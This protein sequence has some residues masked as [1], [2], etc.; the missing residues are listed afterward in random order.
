MRDSNI[1]LLRLFCIIAI[2]AYH[3]CVY[4]EWEYD[5]STIS[6][7]RFFLQFICV[8]G[9]LGVNCFVLIS[10]YYLVEKERRSPSSI[11]KIWLAL[12][13]Y[14]LLFPTVFMLFGMQP[15]SV[16]ELAFSCAPV[17]RQTWEFASA[18]FVLMLLVPYINRLLKVLS[19]KEYQR[20]LILVLTIWCLIPTLTSRT[21]ESNY[22]IWLIVM[23][24]IGGYLRKFP[25]AIMQNIKVTLMGTVLSLVV[26][27]LSFLALDVFGMHVSL[28]ANWIRE[29]RFG[30]MQMIPCVALSVFLFLTFKNLKIK[31]SSIIN[32]LAAATFGVFLIHDHPWVREYIWSSLLNPTKYYESPYLIVY[33][34]FCV[35]L[36][37]AF[38]QILEQFR[39]LVEIQYMKPIV[40]LLD[41]VQHHIQIG[42]PK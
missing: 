16:K 25:S 41:N 39:L 6:V 9:K 40:R 28:F 10:G 5:Y 37:F 30:K 3:F 33:A 35:I 29:V 18:Y 42:D 26:Y 34:L 32:R 38:G 19:Q 23:Y 8:G 31:Q 2:I 12:L 11:A 4:S 27:V 36:I 24:C 20:M 7:N 14:S 17:L 22:L 13:T 21:F 1:E 15:R